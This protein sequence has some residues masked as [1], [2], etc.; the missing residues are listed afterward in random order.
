MLDCFGG[1]C[2][3]LNFA[4]AN[5]KRLVENLIVQRVKKKKNPWIESSWS[6]TDRDTH[7]ERERE[8]ESER[9][10]ERELNAEQF[11]VVLKLD[12]WNC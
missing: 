11:S 8:R 3:T 10:R 12:C 1:C 5:N 2:W 7:T 6:L 9:E 4:K